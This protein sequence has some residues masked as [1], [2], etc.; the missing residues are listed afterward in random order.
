M[1]MLNYEHN[2]ETLNSWIGTVGAVKNKTSLIG[3]GHLKVVYGYWLAMDFAGNL[4]MQE[5]RMAQRLPRA[6]PSYYV[7]TIHSCY[8]YRMTIVVEYLDS[9]KDNFSSFLCSV[10]IGQV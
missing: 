10:P 8:H 2:A 3:I 4:G 9:F 5:T 1:L 6:V 7:R